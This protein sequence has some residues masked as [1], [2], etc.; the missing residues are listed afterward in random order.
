MRINILATAIAAVGSLQPGWGASISAASGVVGLTSDS[1]DKEW[2][3][4]TP[5]PKDTIS[6]SSC[7]CTAD[8]SPYG[9]ANYG[10]E[11]K[12]NTAGAVPLGRTFAGFSRDVPGPLGSHTITKGSGSSTVST[13][14]IGAVPVSG[15][16]ALWRVDATGTLGTPSPSF[17][18]LAPS[19]GSQATGN[20][21]W[22]FNV[23]D[24]TGLLTPTYDLF[25]EAS[26]QQGDFYPDGKIGL[27]LDYMTAGGLLDIL[28]ITLD[29]TGAH[30]ASGGPS[31]LSVYL[32]S[33]LSEGPTGNPSELMSLAGLQTY[34]Q[35]DLNGGSLAAPVTLGIELDH[36]A[37]PTTDLGDGT[38][39][40]INVDTFVTDAA[41]APEPSTVGLFGAGVLG[42]LVCH[43]RRRTSNARA[44]G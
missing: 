42:L 34:L 2:V 4:T 16:V 35:N 36:L 33:D 28:D 43:R 7:P 18:G 27:H 41:T 29:A 14:T 15:Y 30:V 37:I 20:D 10:P 9:V 31:G 6:W 26:L 11:Q 24:F 39:A 44:N 13:V 23:A 22:S 3:L 40:K 1:G 17:P 38:V 32:L 12:F 19:W 5:G 25:F 21:P 8:G